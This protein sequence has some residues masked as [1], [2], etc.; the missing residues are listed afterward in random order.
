MSISSRR[1]SALKSS[2]SIKSISNTAAKFS[3][4]L[5]SARSSSQDI[6]KQLRETN[7][8]KRN[9]IRK[10]NIFF[11][12]RQEN[13]RRKDRED[14]L[15]ASSVT[16]TSKRQGSLL[17]K[18]TRGFLG[19]ILDFLGILLLGWA[20]TNLPK[21]LMGINTLI[22]NIKRVGGIL[23]FFVNGVKDV[24]LGIGSI[25]GA[26]LGK[27]LNFDFISNKSKID[28][29]L[30]G[31]QGN[32]QKTQRELAESANLFSDPENF[33][34][35]NP[36]GFEVDTP[37]EQ[38]SKET[39]NVSDAG[40]EPTSVDGNEG[41][42]REIEGVVNDI[43]KSVE[44]KGEDPVSIE[45]ESDSIE[46]VETDTGGVTPQRGGGAKSAPATA[47]SSIEDPREVL[48]KK[49]DE[50]I[51]RN[52]KT[53]NRNDRRKSSFL[54][55]PNS[56]ANINES[57]T[58]T[59]STMLASVDEYNADFESGQ[60]GSRK[61]NLSSLVTPTKKDVDVKTSR[62]PTRTVM[63]MEKPVDMSSPSVA[64][65]SGGGG[66]TKL[67]SSAVEDEKTL[68]KLQSSSTLK[69]T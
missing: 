38:K 60:G 11:R 56:V 64:M 54:G 1:N 31:T 29:E 4:S 24:V 68:M 61:V 41:E 3:K 55:T 26:T 16:G 40:A 67:T 30:E 69:Y 63:I 6:Q 23:G 36:P 9:L 59:E 39:S 13:I 50:S 48:K 18:S 10:D 17:A 28:K 53:K 35:E 51:K 37:Q 19:R 8:F 65:A 25:I 58:P 22:N 27:L 66:G 21:I 42:K 52:Q 44:S 14:E 15:E 47:S 57:V 45:G 33:G 2:I 7:Q 43:G 20:A 5:S 32:V 49:Q 46:G 62:K 34:L 12:R